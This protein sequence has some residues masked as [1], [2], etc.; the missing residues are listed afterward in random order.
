MQRSHWHSWHVL[1]P[2]VNR[3]SCC[4]YEKENICPTNCLCQEVWM[5]KECED[6]ENNKTRWKGQRT[7]RWSLMSNMAPQIT[8]NATVCSKVCL[9]LHP[10][11]PPKKNQSSEL[12]VLCEGN[13]PVTGGFP[14]QRACNSE[15]ISMPW[16][17]HQCI[18]YITDVLLRWKCH[19]G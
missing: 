17:H 7:L 2:F 10:T 4:L 13:P 3:A 12:L 6:I 14:S 16:R 5:W 11:P 1:D 19:E 15:S 8:G 18:W 9:D